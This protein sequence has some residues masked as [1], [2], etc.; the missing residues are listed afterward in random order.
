MT[1]LLHTSPNRL[2]LIR[3]FFCL[4][5]LFAVLTSVTFAK[6][7]F[8]LTSGDYQEIT[9]EHMEFLEG[10]SPDTPLEVLQSA[11]WQDTLPSKQAYVEGFWMKFRLNNQSTA[12]TFD[13]GHYGEFLRAELQSGY[14]RHSQTD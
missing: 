4:G 12:T 3:T 8:T 2:L 14:D 13:L 11:D 10:V 6:D 5:L 7:P 9:R 1:P